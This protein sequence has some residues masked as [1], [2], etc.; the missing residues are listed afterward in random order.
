MATEIISYLYFLVD[1][2]HSAFKVGVSSNPFKRSLSIPEE[3][4]I[5]KSLQFSCKRTE[6][7]RIEKT[8]H[9][10]FDAY[11]SEKSRGDGFT[12]WFSMEVFEEIRHFV[13]SNQD[14]LR[15]ISYGS[16][17]SSREIP[18]RAGI[19]RRG[20]KR[21]EE[22]PSLARLSER[23]RRISNSKGDKML[24][25]SQ[26]TEEIVA[27]AG[28]HEVFE[29]DKTQF[30]K[31]YLNGVKVFQGLT[32]AGAKVFELVYMIVQESPGADRFYL[33]LMDAEKHGLKISRPVFH[34]GLSELI[35]KEFIF[36]SVMPNIY[37]L[38]VDYL[39][40]GNRLAFIK[41]FRL[42]EKRKTLEKTA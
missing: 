20:F 25:I 27:P 32:S 23:T 36:E 39:F 35:E 8:I 22:N 18:K 28:F 38:N 15:W 40:N 30:V 29:V 24:I 7:Y 41:E 16:I 3:I 31:L 2:Q 26:E 9:F 42:K 34:R 12:E 11:R 5:E 21:Y 1:I 33:H 37:F 6:V 14:K 19:S 13:L 10:L 4:D 17:N